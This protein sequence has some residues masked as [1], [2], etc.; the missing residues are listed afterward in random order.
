MTRFAGDA[1]AHYQDPRRLD[2]GAQAQHSAY[3][4]AM[5]DNAEMMG[6]YKIKSAENQGQLAVMQA[7]AQGQIGAMNQQTENQAG[8]VGTL[9]GVVSDFVAPA[10]GGLFKPPAASS[11]AAS[12]LGTG[13]VN[14][15]SS[16]FGGF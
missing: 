13:A 3:N 11:S 2:F 5:V 4:Q 14:M 9:G 1:F 16:I 8:L 6:D 10:V 12:R 15:A 7:D